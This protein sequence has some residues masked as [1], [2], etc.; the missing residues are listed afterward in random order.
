[1]AIPQVTTQ[2]L[3]QQRLGPENYDWARL[4]SLDAEIAMAVYM[5]TQVIATAVTLGRLPLQGPGIELCQR[6]LACH[7]YCV[8]DP[9][10]MSKSTEGASGS[11]QR[12]SD[13]G[14]DLT[15]YGRT[16]CQLDFSGVLTAYGKRQV[17]RARWVGALANVGI[18]CGW[19]WGE[20]SYVTQTPNPVI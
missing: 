6:N 5:V 1:M 12:K 8:K 3:V 19:A 13:N 4:P 14:F 2:A 10:Y 9:L 20:G 16:A 18:L 15:E 11:F 17:A 7:F